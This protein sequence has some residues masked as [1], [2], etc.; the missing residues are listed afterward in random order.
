MEILFTSL[1]QIDHASNSLKE[2]EI[3]EYGNDLTDYVNRII[4]EIVERTSKQEFRFKRDTTEVRG[5]ISEFLIGNYD[6]KETIAKRLIDVE[7]STQE[8][9]TNLNTEIQRGSLFQAHLK[10]SESSTI[11]IIKADQQQFLTSDEFNLK[12]G[13]PWEKKIFKAFLARIE[14][15]IVVETFV[16]DTSTRPSVYWWD[17]FLELEEVNTPS[18]NTRK[19][20]KLLDNKVFNPIKKKFKADH[21]AIRNKAVGYFQTQTTFEMKSFLDIVINDYKPVDQDF[22]KTETIQKIKN[23]PE[24][25]KF[26]SQFPIATEE[27]KARKI[28]NNIQLSK[29]ME[30]I[31]KENIPELDSTVTSFLDT[32][33]RKYIKIRTDTGYDHF[34]SPIN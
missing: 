12:Q 25:F 8:E 1:H 10:E 29:R 16:Y 4:S 33:G 27:I 30:L 28:Q 11:I 2:I 32:E 6:G 9:I 34:K 24:K 18:Y 15:N 17:K 31:L 20:L 13:L 14:D 26:D 22:P 3:K 23:L 5:V 19:A 7:K 21:T